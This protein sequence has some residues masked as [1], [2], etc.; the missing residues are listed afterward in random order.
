MFPCPMM[1]SLISTEGYVVGFLNP[2]E[3]IFLVQLHKR[4][5]TDWLGIRI[6]LLEYLEILQY[7]I[8]KKFVIILLE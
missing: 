2:R 6:I 3:P 7:I 5:K 4:A 8:C 1:L